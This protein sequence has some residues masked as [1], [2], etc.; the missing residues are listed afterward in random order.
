MSPRLVGRKKNVA[1]GHTYTDSK[2]RSKST[3]NGVGHARK[4]LKAGS[5]VPAASPNQ[6]TSRKAK[7][8]R[9]HLLR[10]RSSRVFER[11]NKLFF[12]RRPCTLLCLDTT[13]R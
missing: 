5:S 3:Q 12:R 1:A 7:L 4:S 10:P 8:G 11:P 13:Q 9:R 6:F 2:R